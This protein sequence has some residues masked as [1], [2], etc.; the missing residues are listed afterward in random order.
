MEQ[1]QD[2]PNKKIDKELW[3]LIED[4]IKKGSYLF[5]PHAKKRQKDRNI[6]DIDVLDI[7]ENKP[8]RKRNRNKKKDSYTK[9]FIDW[10][11]CIEGIDLDRKNKIRVIISFQEIFN[12]S[13]LLVITVIRLSNSE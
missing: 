13:N 2:K 11:Y 12:E 7:L 6:S 5:L 8:G 1:K 3:H 9:G 4:K 10:N